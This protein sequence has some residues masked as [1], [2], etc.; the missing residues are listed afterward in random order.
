LRLSLYSDEYSESR[1]NIEVLDMA[2]TSRRVFLALLA[3]LLLTAT[4]PAQA[5]DLLV[6][7]AASLKNAAEDIG[8]AYEASGAGKV[9][10]SFAASSDLAKQ[11]E[12][13]AP[14]AIFISA[15]TKWMDYLAERKAI[16]AD[17]RRDLLGNRLVLIAPA[18]SMLTLDLAAGAPL[19]QSLGD[20]KLTMADPDSVP[21]GRYGKAALESLQLWSSVE[22][23]VVR[24]KD[25]RAT[26][27]FVERGEAAAGIVYATDAM[28]S[29]KVRIVE[30]FPESSHPKIVYPVALI[31]GQDDAAAH[32][33]Y[34][35]LV[36]P[37]ARGV[38]L[39]Y[40]FSIIG[41]GA[42]TN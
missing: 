13:G 20:G 39:D 29:K 40:G 3:G 11:I 26:L 42:A 31:A 27:A 23:A 37:K 19:A 25:V 36:G 1:C 6:F 15:D 30:E 32:A 7:A 2:Q 18:D 33:F 34:D 16:V 41:A 24:A 22:P 28:V 12:N 9:T 8:K 4:V 35:Y 14:A 38:F 17:S 5:K 10:Y 21:A